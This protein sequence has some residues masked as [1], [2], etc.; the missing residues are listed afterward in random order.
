MKEIYEMKGAGCSVRGIAG[1]LGIA[2]NTVRRYLK[3]P[4]AI[5]AKRSTAASIQA[6]PLHRVRRPSSRRGV[7]ELRGA[8]PGADGPGL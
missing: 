1:E 8:A 4:E 2:R 7:G 3:S 6:G 5:R